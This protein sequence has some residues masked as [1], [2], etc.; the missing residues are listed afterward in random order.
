MLAFAT[1]DSSF[2][3]IRRRTSDLLQNVQQNLPSMPAMPAMT[4]MPTMPSINLSKERTM[5]GTWERIDLP[6][7]PR[8]SHSVN[9]ISGSAYVFGGELAARQ[10]AD[11]DM[12]VI[13]LP[14]SSASADYYKVKA[15][16]AKQGGWNQ[17]SSTAQ[18]EADELELDEVPLR[19][20]VP[21][22]AEE[23]GKGKAKAVDEPPHSTVP[24]ARVGH[25]TA[26]IG[27]RIFMFGGRGGPDMKPLEEGGRVW[28]FH[29]RSNDW[30]YLDP[31]PAVK[32]GTIIPHPSA[33]SDHCATATDR[34]RDF[35]QPKPAQ[36]TNWRERFVGD[37]S[38]TGIPQAPVVGN[39][40]EEA[41]DEETEGYGTFFVHGGFLA[42]GERTNDLWAFDV[43][44]RTWTEMPAAPGPARGG[45]AICIS[46]S[47]LFRFGGFDGQNEIGGQ[48]DFVHL[49][50]EMFD[51]SDSRGEV[52]IKARGR[53]QSI[54]QN[55][56]DAS[57]NDFSVEP[58]QAWPGPRSVASFHALTMGG[59]R[60]FL[61]LAMGEGSPSSEREAGAGQFYSDVWAFQVPP[62]GMTAASLTDAVFQAMGRKTGEGK[63][64]KVVTSPYD[65]DNDD[66]EPLS[67]GWMASA[68][69]ADLEESAIVIWGGLGADN[70]R[71]GDGWILRF[72]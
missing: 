34:P 23:K 60:E 55:N 11:N 29:T 26:S 41:V 50:V 46:K 18:A 43:R 53:W 51:D 16:A 72:A 64:F 47:R 5:N 57:S 20:D 32:G 36:P 67:R 21:A 22:T 35:A 66:G 39:V 69:M 9:I 48:L 49:E 1:M 33:R 59:G 28:V 14:W 54:I 68:V 19:E 52:A 63:W 38:K 2:S 44:T 24:G 30:S 45:T 71:L 4:G 3:L 17:T 31:V 25:V 40:A 15:T 7:V 37:T 62:L 6:P 70:R 13:T 10:P 56:A 61:V 8:S 42:D 12:H 27:N 58:A 65:D